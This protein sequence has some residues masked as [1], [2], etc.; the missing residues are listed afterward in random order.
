MDHGGQV[1]LTIYKDFPDLH[2]SFISNYDVVLVLDA[3]KLSN[4]Y[5]IERFIDTSVDKDEGE[6]IIKNSINNLKDYILWIGDNGIDINA[7]NYIKEY[8]PNIQIKKWN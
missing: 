1:S 5:D 6:W 3:Y 7:M 8:Y 2:T 4:D